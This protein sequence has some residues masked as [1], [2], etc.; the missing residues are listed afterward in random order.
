MTPEISVLLPVRDAA[1]TLGAALESLRRQTFG[2]FECVVADD[3]SR[4]GSRELAARVCAEDPRFELLAL[5]R[6]GLV[7]A[8]N[9][10][11]AA[12]RGRFV[13]RMDADDVC[14][15]FRFE[16]Q[17]ETLLADP[18]LAAAGCHVR[19]FPRGAR[20]EGRL[21]YERWLNSLATPEDVR[22]DRF[23]E[24][25]VAHP[26][27]FARGELLRRHAYRDTGWAEDYDLVLRLL[28][29]GERV[30]VTPRRLLLW[31]DGAERHSRAHARYAPEAFVECK[32][33]FLAS[34]FLAAANTYV[35]WGYGDTGRA[36]AR[37]LARRGKRPSHIVEIHP[38]RIGE[39]IFDAPVIAPPGLLELPPPKPRVVVSVAGAEARGIIRGFLS[40]HGFGEDSDYVCA[41]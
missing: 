17:R 20:A 28:G 30:G 2:D 1:A 7:E 15:R 19:T 35:L 25:P 39:R 21:R 29:D 22:R 14:S 32:A 37:A 11:L 33:E 38:R 34:S 16:A 41:A 9:D 40:T 24:C 12:C 3:G 27:L 23:V 8:L 31:R 13:A 10:G 4:D 6:R 26:T 5:P 18:T 36:L